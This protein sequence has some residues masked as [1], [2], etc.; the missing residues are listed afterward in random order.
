MAPRQR[1]AAGV[2]LALVAAVGGTWLILWHDITPARVEDV[3]A[4]AGGWAPVAFVVLFAVATVLLLPG[5]VFAVVGGMAFGPVWGA[6][7]NLLGATIGATLAFLI[8]RYV[9]SDWVAR[10][11]GGRLKRVV[12]GVEAEG[13]RFI[14]LMRL[15]PVVPFNI[16]NFAV[17]LTRIPVA[18]YVVATA[19]CMAPGAVAY[20]WLGH[21]GRGAMEGH[22]AAVEYSLLGLAVLAVLAF[23]PRLWRRIL[24]KKD[25]WIDTPELRRTLAGQPIPI[26]VD[27]RDPE[28][29][30]GPLGSIPGALNIPISDLPTR[31]REA[32]QQRP[33][34]MVCRTDKRS[35]RAAELLRA[36]GVGD[37]SVL[38]GGM[39]AWAKTASRSR[40]G[41]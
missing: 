32:N 12:E 38:R 10:K 34:V 23:L 27:V 7:W 41:Q 13:W 31:W 18:Q 5:A 9:A 24:G 40:V 36:K 4:S 33:V 21:A 22:D 19:V 28:E 14:A 8:A 39:E 6:V 30:H 15:V 11:I 29:F 37:V 17:G 16:F 26:V 1:L 35:A 25:G 20:T 2:V 3:I